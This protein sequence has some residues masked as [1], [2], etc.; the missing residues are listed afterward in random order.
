MISRGS[1]SN[2]GKRAEATAEYLEN[3]QWGDVN[4]TP[5]KENPAKVHNQGIKI[6]KGN[7]K[8]KELDL[9]LKKVKKI[10]HLA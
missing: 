2:L 6:K 7:V 4:D 10:K 1:A 9:V 8:M 3:K 5:P